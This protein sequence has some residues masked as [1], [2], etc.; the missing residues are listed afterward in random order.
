MTD[1]DVEVYLRT[2]TCQI[3]V[4]GKPIRKREV[5]ATRTATAS[6]GTKTRKATALKSS[7]AFAQLAAVVQFSD[8]A[9]ISASP[10]GLIS[11]WNPSAARIFGY[12]EAEAIGKPLEIITPVSQKAGLLN[13]ESRVRRGGHI[14]NL[15]TECLKKDGRL[16]DVALTVSPILH[17]QNRK[18]VGAAI[19]ARDISRQKRAEEKLR[20]SESFYHS[21]V[22]YLPQNIFRKDLAGHF[23]FANQR[24]CHTL[25]VTLKE[26]V[27]KSD[28]DYFPAELA[29][30]YQLDDHR[31]VETGLPFETVEINQPPGG[32]KFYVHVCK[33]P[34]YDGLGKTVGVQG[35]FWDI[36]ASREAENALRE[37]EERYKKLL[38]SVTDYIYTVELVDGHPSATRHGP[39]CLAVTGYTQEEYERSPF[40]WYQMIHE[41][42]REAVVNQIQRLL[43]GQAEPLDHRIIHR[44]GTTRYV[45][46]TPV[47]R[48]DNRGVLIAYDGLVS[49]ITERKKAE[50]K[51]M[52]ANVELSH[53]REGLMQALADLNRSH[54]E[55]K[56][57]QMLLIRA[58]KMETVGRL[59]AGVAHEVKN[60]LAILLSGVEYLAAS[61]VAGDDNVSMVLRDMRDALKRAD[62][63][64][65][66][67]LD[68]A[69]AQELG[70]KPE[71]LNEIV[72]RTLSLMRHD[73]ARSGIISEKNLQ[74]DLPMVMLD[75]N[76][77]EQVLL[78]LFLNAVHA[79]PDGGKLCVTTRA[80]QLNEEEIVR[81]A[82]SRSASRFRA[83][84]WVVEVLVEDTGMG[85]ATELLT[86]IFEPFFTTK[87]TGKGTGLG[88]AVT[89]KIMD[90][91]GANIHLQN[92][93]EGGVRVTLGF[94]SEGRQ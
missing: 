21:L 1:I 37:S 76:K 53:S 54:D 67:L 70:V 87:P 56:A 43:K 49:D 52:Q 83:G 59:A 14:A 88:L 80:R 4:K 89:K 12:S 85:I 65:R 17:G 15:E 73:M 78:N 36:T 92:R 11:S 75:R 58:E 18:F 25:G 8:D 7:E 31:V 48:Y 63:V 40:L 2:D 74:Q 33:T 23:T 3:M 81:D 28:Y 90:M 64:I 79:M 60:P 66:G 57:A 26:V 16:I 61:P 72:E 30:K 32:G 19:I 44:D 5:S 38:S 86:K 77:M 46:N 50:E 93:P 51:L 29:A 10:D 24:F 94:K 47:P 6:S 34:I 68:F 41:E 20:T 27:G 39:G 55:L 13:V 62:T 42:D 71:N 69:A 82:G 9:I 91:H 35:I 84:D 45:R 22:E